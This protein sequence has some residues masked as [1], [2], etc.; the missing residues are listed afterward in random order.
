MSF[1]FC[2]YRDLWGAKDE[3]FGYRVFLFLSTRGMVPLKVAQTAQSMLFTTMG[4]DNFRVCHFSGST[5]MKCQALVQC[6]FLWTN[7]H[8]KYK[9]F[10]KS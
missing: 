5:F 1:V 2:G 3:L 8:Y 10:S 9:L 4:V 7:Q 6:Y